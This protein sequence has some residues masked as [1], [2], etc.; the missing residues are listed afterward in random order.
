MD[1]Y[2]SALDLSLFRFDTD[3]DAARIFGEVEIRG[4]RAALLSDEN[5]VTE[6]RDGLN[7]TNATAQAII[8]E[9]EAILEPVVRIE[10][11]K[12]AKA[13][14]KLSAATQKRVN[15]ML[16]ELNKLAAEYTGAPTSIGPNQKQ[17]TGH[18][19]DATSDT[20]PRPELFEFIPRSLTLT[21]GV[22]A[23]VSLY[24]NTKK[25]SGEAIIDSDSE[26][27]DYS[28]ESFTID[29]AV[30][31]FHQAINLR[32]DVAGSQGTLVVVTDA[33][34]AELSFKVE[35]VPYPVPAE[36]LEFIPG[37]KDVTAGRLRTL[38]LYVDLSKVSPHSL[39]L[40]ELEDNAIA[41][42]GQTSIRVDP[43]SA[44]GDVVHLPVKL[45]GR[46][47]GAKTLVVA[48]V[49]ALRATCEVEVR[50][51]K[52][53]ER[54]T[55]GLFSGIEFE[56]KSFP[57][58]WYRADDEKMVINTKEPSFEYIRVAEGMFEYDRGV[59]VAVAEACTQVACARISERTIA[60]GGK[61][62]WYLSNDPVKRTQEDRVFT[63]Q[64]TRVV[65]PVIYRNL[66]NP[67]PRLP[68][69]NGAAVAAR[70]GEEAP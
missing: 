36:G 18:G 62:P 58:C 27:L 35:A 21:P 25:C 68:T 44:R 28:P 31:V 56:E 33:G 69:G 14:K 22:P 49:N 52:A 42:L 3:P 45:I 38:D 47:V 2:D 12:S 50:S 37:A 32:C 1:E 60:G 41:E 29:S 43:T 48:S 4:L 19:A 63:E 6:E 23:N 34:E 40:L 66:V 54:S 55:G 61:R 46:Q 20:K 67:S 30:E 70:T 5:I 24:I 7:R 53:K 17:S 26:E 51:R 59:Q 13:N 64:L 16:D 39:V 10:R 11:E 65:G 15:S 8:K 57:K 9:I